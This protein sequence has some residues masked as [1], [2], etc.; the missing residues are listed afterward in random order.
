MVSG[1]DFAGV[2]R[3]S[4]FG[5]ARRARI[6]SPERPPVKIIRITDGERVNQARELMEEYFQPYRHN[7]SQDA[8]F[9]ELS[10]V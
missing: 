10:L 2:P 8:V 6:V 1:E 7:P 4:G 5:L 3:L 9:M